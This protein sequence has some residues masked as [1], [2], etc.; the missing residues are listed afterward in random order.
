MA[1]SEQLIGALR[2]ARQAKAVRGVVLLIDSPGGSVLASDRIYHEVVRLA[3]KKPV[4]AYFVNVA[5]SGGYYVAAGAHAI[6]AQPTTVTGSI[7]VVATHLVLGPLLAK[8]GIVTELVKRGARADMLSPSRPLDDGERAAMIRDIDG[9]YQEFVEIVARGRGRPPGEI[10]KLAR[11][12]VYS[13]A[14]AHRLGLV[15]HLGGFDTALDVVRE[16]LGEPRQLEAALIKA[17]RSTPAPPELPRPL[18]SLLESAPLDRIREIGTLALS[19]G[20]GE[21]VLAWSELAEIG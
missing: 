16:R 20:A 6:V 19:L 7:G 12:R 1:D 5:A 11:G 17:P 3:E 4:V 15:D 13:G 14:E 2:V 18:V 9:Y 8:L 21:T 10:E